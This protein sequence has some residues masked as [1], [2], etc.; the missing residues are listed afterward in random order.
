M[1][2][3]ENP[4]KLTQFFEKIGRTTVAGVEEVGNGGVMV[5]ESLYWLFFGYR[6]KQPV[7]LNAVIQQMM[8]IGISAIPIIALLG[9]SISVTLAIQA[10]IRCVFSARKATSRPAWPLSWSGNSRP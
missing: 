3:T 9:V 2:S 7:R 10:S 5:S 4:G 1:P 6:M 8:D